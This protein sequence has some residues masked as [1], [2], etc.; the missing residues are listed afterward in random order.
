MEFNDRRKMSGFEK[1]QR[2]HSTGAIST[3]TGMS[4]YEVSKNVTVKGG[5]A[6][7]N[8]AVQARY[9]NY[10]KPITTSTK[11]NKRALKSINKGM[12]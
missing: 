4:G 12:K 5:N 2:G 7:S 9:E 11:G 6:I 3:G 1:A 10:E 8:G